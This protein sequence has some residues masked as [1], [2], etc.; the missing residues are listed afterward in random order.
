MASIT[1]G[2]LLEG[3]SR[4]EHQGGANPGSREMPTEIF[5]RLEQPS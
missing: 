2:L 3:P 1:P 5:D 4:L